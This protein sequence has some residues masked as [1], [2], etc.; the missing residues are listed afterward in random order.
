MVYCILFL[1]LSGCALWDWRKKRIPN[2]WTAFWW[3]FLGAFCVWEDGRFSLN[4]CLIYLADTAIPMLLLFPFY[5]VRMMGAGDIKMLSVITAAAGITE[6]FSIIFSG[7][8]AAAVWSFVYMVRRHILLKRICY[9]FNYM[10]KLQ[11]AMGILPYCGRNPGDGEAQFCL[12]PFILA[13]FLLRQAAGG[14]I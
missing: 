13:G 8:T 4:T 7:L 12:A 9:F 2:W 10:R 6:G 3:A 5:L 14:V 1:Y 11:K